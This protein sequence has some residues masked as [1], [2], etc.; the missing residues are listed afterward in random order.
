MQQRHY[1]KNINLSGFMYFC[2]GVH[3]F[4][5]K[6]ISISGMLVQLEGTEAVFYSNR[7]LEDMCL[8]NKSVDFFIPDSNIS[9]VAEVSRV[10]SERNVLFFVGMEFKDIVYSFGK[11][12]FNRKD[13]RAPVAIPGRLTLKGKQFDVITRNVS[14]E[15]LMVRAPSLMGVEKDMILE[16]EFPRSNTK[17]WVRVVWLVD[18][19]NH[20]DTLM[21]LQYVKLDECEGALEERVTSMLTDSSSTPA[22][23][24]CAPSISQEFPSGFLDWAKRAI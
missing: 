23:G 7:V 19:D 3:N 1:R 12:C 17:S 21:G 8:A 10:F 14:A 11:P 22:A 2:G 16:L 5:V 6:N 9:G 20:F 13:Y 15:G 4:L 24:F 18:D